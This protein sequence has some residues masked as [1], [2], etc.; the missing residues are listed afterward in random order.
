METGAVEGPERHVVLV[1][2]EVHWN[3]GNAGR[4][5]L[6]AGACLHLIKPL[7]FSLDSAQVKRAG[8]DYWEHVRL[9]VWENFE[10]F[11]EAMAPQPGE[12]ALFAK[13]GARP[14]W[15]MPKPKRLFLVFGSETKGL[16]E[17][18]LTRYP[19]ARYHIPITRAV[20]CLNLS[21]SVGVALYE[22]L[23]GAGVRHGWGAEAG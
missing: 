22:S 7:G 2:P 20:R 18:V 8:L 23:R 14:F 16:P 6:G 15:E 19:Q 9:F 3:T 11:E 13:L 4:T 5:C 17:A 10:A 12:V 1:A 21:T